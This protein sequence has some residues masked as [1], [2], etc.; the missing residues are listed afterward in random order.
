MCV[1]A[2]FIGIKGI[3]TLINDSIIPRHHLITLTESINDTMRMSYEIVCIVYLQLRSCVQHSTRILVV[4]ILQRLEQQVYLRPTSNFS[5]KHSHEK[6]Y[7]KT[8]KLQNLDIK[9]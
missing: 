4:A 6:L 1:V 5:R 2:H 3:V 8:S 7:F 9:V